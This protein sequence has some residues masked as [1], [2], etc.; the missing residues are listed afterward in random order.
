M[1]ALEP[2]S[3]FD[4]SDLLFDLLIVHASGHLQLLA[5]GPCENTDDYASRGDRRDAIGDLLADVRFFPLQDSYVTFSGVAIDGLC[6]FL[7]GFLGYRRAG[8]PEM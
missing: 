4:F 3:L 5:F 1:L 6:H 2:A 7:F 8:H